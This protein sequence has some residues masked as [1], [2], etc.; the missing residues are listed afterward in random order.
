VLVRGRRP[1]SRVDGRRHGAA[2]RLTVGLSGG[3]GGLGLDRRRRVRGASRRLGRRRPRPT[4]TAAAG[5]ACA[6]GARRLPGT[7][8]AC[9]RSSSARLVRKRVGE[10]APVSSPAGRTPSGGQ[11]MREP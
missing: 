8:T 4:G 5:P 7:P 1:A 2:P 11:L 10:T 6:A 3:F 9:S